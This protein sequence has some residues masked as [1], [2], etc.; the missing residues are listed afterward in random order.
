MD[1]PVVVSVTILGNN[2][3]IVCEEAEKEALLASASY[4]DEKM[5]DVKNTGK[6]VGSEKI[7]VM[8]ALNISHELLQDKFVDHD[9]TKRIRN[10]LNH[11]TEKMELVLNESS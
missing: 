8:A 3:R 7:A 6:V 10:R 1:K 11:L 5:Q 9:R 4:L 2:Y